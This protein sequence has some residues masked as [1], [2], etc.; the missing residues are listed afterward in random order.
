MHHE[1]LSSHEIHSDGILQGDILPTLGHDSVPH[2]G[3]EGDS[4]HH[5]TAAWPSLHFS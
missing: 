2:Q 5:F 1:H 3:P 4:Q